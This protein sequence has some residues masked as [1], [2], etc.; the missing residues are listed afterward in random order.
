MATKFCKKCRDPIDPSQYQEA[1][2][3]G[4]LP[5]QTQK[6]KRADYCYECFCELAGNQVPMVTDPTLQPPGT[7]TVPRQQYKRGHTDGG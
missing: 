1:R 7:H 2:E 3:I 6:Y 4:S 5:K